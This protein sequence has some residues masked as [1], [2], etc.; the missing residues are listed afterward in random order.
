[1]IICPHCSNRVP[2]NMR[3]CPHCGRRIDVDFD[4]IKEQLADEKKREDWAKKEKESRKLLAIAVFLFLLS[5]TF[6][7]SA[8]ESWSPNSYPV[9]APPA[10]EPQRQKPQ[11]WLLEKTPKLFL[12]MPND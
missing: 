6:F 8:P 11:E 7:L 1:M 12:D 2:P 5:L 9:W 3:F 10:P 4:Q